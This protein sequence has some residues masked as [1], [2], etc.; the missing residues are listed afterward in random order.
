MER[1]CDFKVEQRQSDDG[2]LFWVIVA[3]AHRGSMDLF[4]SREE[5]NADY[6]TAILNKVDK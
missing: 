4:E 5:S 6:F 2:Y 3:N 1:L